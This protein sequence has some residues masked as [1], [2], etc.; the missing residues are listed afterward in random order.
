MTR[1]PEWIAD[2]APYKNYDRAL[3]IV[4]LSKGDRVGTLG[5]TPT[6]FTNFWSAV[7]SKTGDQG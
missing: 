6:S 2:I 5:A 4:Q 3:G 7:S 1:S